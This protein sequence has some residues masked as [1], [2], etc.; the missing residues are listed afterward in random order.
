MEKK[1]TIRYLG[2]RETEV[3]SRLS[4]EHITLVTSAQ[5]SMLF[6]FSEGVKKQVLHRLKKKGIFRPIKRGIYLY[7]PLDAGPY[8]SQ[9]NEWR[10]PAVLYP[11]KNYYVGYSVMYNYYGFTEQIFQTMHLLNTTHHAQREIGGVV[12]KSVKISSTR[13]YGIQT[14]RIHEADVQVSDL[15]KT[16]VDLLYFPN[17]VGGIRA[18]FAIFTKQA[19]Q[20]KVDL[21]K[22]VHY[23]MQFPNSRVQKQIGFLLESIGVSAKE[24]RPLKRSIQN[25]ALTTLVS[26]ES[27]KGE[28]NKTWGLILNVA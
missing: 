23:A 24:L 4:H 19:S 21:R 9:I 27:R 10:I 17:P 6:K 18:A 2:P 25:T 8:G 22:L 5:F 1:R 13:L 26:G 15:E 28:I 14:L 16:L 3:I 20:Q 7:S 11:Q 12:F